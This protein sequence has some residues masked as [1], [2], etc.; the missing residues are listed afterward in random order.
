MRKGISS[1]RRAFTLVELLITV[2]VI[3]ILAVIAIPLFG[4]ATQR[5]RESALRGNLN[6][7]RGAMARFVQD[8]GCYPATLSD[9]TLPANA[10]PTWGKD[11]T[12]HVATIKAGTYLG[13]YIDFIPSDPIDGSALN[14]NSFMP[15]TIGHVYANSGAASDGSDYSYW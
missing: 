4:S 6:L 11:S 3:A 1:R 9:M 14:Y 10:P 12:N 8:T 2:I 7:L 13:P 15:P 5:G